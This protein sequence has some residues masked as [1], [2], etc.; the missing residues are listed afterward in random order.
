MPDSE[1]L[2]GYRST[3][4]DGQAFARAIVRELTNAGTEC[5]YAVFSIG[6]GPSLVWLRQRSPAEKLRHIWAEGCF[7][8]QGTGSAPSAAGTHCP[9]DPD[10][11]VAP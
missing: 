3:T 7:T 2:A 10:G 11:T 8:A 5:D 1:Y 6:S 4:A 9:D